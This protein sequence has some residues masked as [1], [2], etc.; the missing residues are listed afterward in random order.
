[1]S[2]LYPMLALAGREHGAAAGLGSAVTGVLC[3]CRRVFLAIAREIVIVGQLFAFG[4]GLDGLDI[5][6]LLIQDCPAVW[7][8][9]MI[10]KARI[11]AVH[12]GVDG[13]VL[14]H[15]EQQHMR[16]LRFIVVVTPVGFLRRDAFSDIFDDARPFA[17]A[18]R[19]ESAESVNGGVAN[20]KWL[21][22]HNVL[23]VI[24]SRRRSNLLICEG[25]ATSPRSGSSQ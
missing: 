23:F 12:R 16:M 14:V 22:V 24:A 11:I 5:D 4:D 21:F 3:F 6:V 13:G 8:A 10:D 9:A 19:G 15:Y 25:I 1:M 17:D 7:L 2:R 20:F 18:L